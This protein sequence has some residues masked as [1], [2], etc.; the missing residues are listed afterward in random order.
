MASVTG[1][2]DRLPQLQDPRCYPGATSPVELVQTHISVVALTGDR[3]FKFKKALR[4]PFLDTLALERREHF[5]REELRLNRRLCA[6]V[7]LDVLALVETPDGLRLLPAPHDRAVDFAVA[8][9][10][11]P[12]ARMLDQLLPDGVDA[13]AI[14]ALARRLAGFHAA[15]E[16][17][18]QVDQLG[19]PERLRQ[20]ALDNFTEL[21]ALPDHGLHAPL[22]AGLERAT[23]ADFAALLPPLQRR[24]AA[25]RIVDGHGD[26]HARNICMQSPPAIYDCIEF[27]PAFRCSDVATEV[28]FLTMDLRYRRAPALAAAFTAAYAAAAGDAELPSLLPGLIRYRAMVRA[29]VATLTSRERELPAADRS[30]AH[31]SAVR[32]LQLAA[33]TAVEARRRWLVVCGPPASGKSALSAALAE[34]GGWPHLNTDV[35]RKQL[36]GVPATARLDAS[37]YSEAA[38]DRTYAELLRR[39][40]A[41]PS[42]VVLLDGNFATPARRAAAAAAARQHGAE[43][44]FVHVGIA[45]AIALERLRRRADD[46]HAVSD[47]GVAQ[48]AQLQARFEAPQPHEGAVVEVDGDQPLADLIDDLLA[49]MLA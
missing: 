19:A 18:P 32:H 1:I 9:R 37:H 33:A 7:Y 45:P 25:G 5:C 11:L 36:A 28:A 17:G 44:L 49:R 43:P 30:G 16:R 6:D 21:A 8:M 34:L 46:S 31:E 12:Q 10:R 47:A 24:A 3:A 29:K 4:L 23:R 13:A 2:V 22:L 14:E 26:L 38:S 20:L 48:F 27:E 15:A 40:A 42:P 35:V 41:S 39:A